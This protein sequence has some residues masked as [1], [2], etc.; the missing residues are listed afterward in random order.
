MDRFDR[1]IQFILEIDKLKSI[2]RRTYLLNNPR[3]ENT[4]EHS[5]HLAIMAI[6]LAEHANESVDV[7]RVV[8]MVLIHDIVEID[9]GD[10]YFYDAAGALDKAEREEAAAE[11]IFGILPPDQ[12]R[13]LKELWEEF[14]AAETADARFALALDRFIPQLHNYHTRGRSWSE[15]GITA[16]RVLE[17]NSEIAEGSERLWECARSLVEDAVAKGFLATRKEK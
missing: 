11:R 5:W 1:Q 8:K 15:H 16:D 13:E 2:V 7:A 9:A 17:R 10:T 4:A 14:E 12:G 6:L 3:A